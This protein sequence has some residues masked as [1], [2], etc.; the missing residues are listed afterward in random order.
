MRRQIAAASML[1]RGRAALSAMDYRHILDLA[2]ESDVVYMDPPYQ[3]VCG[4]RDQ[5]YLPKVDHDEFCEELAKL[6]DRHMM[7]VVSYD[8]RTGTKTYGEPLPDNLKLTH[9]EI[10]AG[11]STQA[12]LLGRTD[13]TFESLYLSPALVASVQREGRTN[14]CQLALW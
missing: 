14:E 1:L 2:T 9:S 6:N 12:T 4:N 5:R 10:R 11:R 8:G 13:V 7:F 3:G